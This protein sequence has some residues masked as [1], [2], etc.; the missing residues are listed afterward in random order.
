MPADRKDDF[1]SALERY[2]TASGLIE[3]EV[4][5]EALRSFILREC[6]P[7]SQIS[8]KL[9]NLRETL[10]DIEHQRWSHWQQYL[11]GRCRPLAD[12][13][14]EIPA[15]LVEQWQR[16]LST[17]YGLLSLKEQKSDLEQVDRYL[18]FIADQLSR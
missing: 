5:I 12:G 11:H 4:N 6:V 8:G 10:A 15:A 1:D 9:G 17:P 14:L 13:G 2:V 16:Q 18:P 7:K 3:A